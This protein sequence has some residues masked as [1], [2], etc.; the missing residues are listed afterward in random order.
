MLKN[1]N[2]K[3]IT[4]LILNYLQYLFLFAIFINIFNKIII[5]PKI[6]RGKQI[7]FFHIK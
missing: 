5:H 3:I 2:K 4:S 6:R 7:Q 1:G